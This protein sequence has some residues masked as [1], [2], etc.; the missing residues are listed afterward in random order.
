MGIHF[1][2]F[3]GSYQNAL[4]KEH[5]ITSLNGNIRNTAIKLFQMKIDWNVSISLA[6][7]VILIGHLSFP[8]MDRLFCPLCWAF[9]FYTFRGHTK[10]ALLKEHLIIS[11][12]WHYS[13]QCIKIILKLN[14][15]KLWPLVLI[16]LPSFPGMVRLINQAPVCLSFE[17][18][19]C[20]CRPWSLVGCWWQICTCCW[21]I[22]SQQSKAYPI[23]PYYDFYY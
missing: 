10:M 8:E 17:R 4:S 2:Y 3:F 12:Y 1:L 18:N 11:L 22:S 5:F 15:R 9:T 19:C 23:I 16:G 20:V 7:M 21:W 14:E 6:F 13:E